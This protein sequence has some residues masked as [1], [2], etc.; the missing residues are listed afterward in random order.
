MSMSQFTVLEKMSVG[1]DIRVLVWCMCRF[2]QG[3][4]DGFWNTLVF[5]RYLCGCFFSMALRVDWRIQI[6]VYAR[7]SP[8]S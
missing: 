1:L 5:C 7:V 8:N 6:S 2:G 4:I 3:L